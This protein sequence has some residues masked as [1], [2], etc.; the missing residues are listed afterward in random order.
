MSRGKGVILQRFREGKLA[1]LMTLNL[2][3]GLT[4]PMG[5]RQRHEKDLT[6]WLGRRAG[7]GRMA[8]MGFPRNNRFR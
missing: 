6:P 2:A 8:P 7:S 1:D 3:D 4:W 5:E